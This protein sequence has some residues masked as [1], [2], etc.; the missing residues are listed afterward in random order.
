MSLPG[1]CTPP[2]NLTLPLPFL[3]ANLPRTLALPACF[4]DQ[5]ALSWL[6]DR[7][8]SNSK[9]GCGGGRR[10]KVRHLHN[11]KA[12]QWA[13]GDKAAVQERAGKGFDT[14]ISREVAQIGVYTGGRGYR[15]DDTK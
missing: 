12:I 15:H 13:Q 7:F 4:Q 11:N 6:T 1:I 3:L 10:E 8:N 14:F 9:K 5:T 2:C